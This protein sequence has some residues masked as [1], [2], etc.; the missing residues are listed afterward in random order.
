MKCIMMLIIYCSNGRIKTKLDVEDE[1]HIALLTEIQ[2]IDD[3]AK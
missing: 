1:L 3:L 2:Y